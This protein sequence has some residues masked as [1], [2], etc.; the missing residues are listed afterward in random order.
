M[1]RAR[2]SRA[3][4]RAR[5]RTSPQYSR[6]GLSTNR[7][8]S[9]CSASAESTLRYS[10]GNVEIPNRHSRSGRAERAIVPARKRRDEALG[11]RGLMPAAEAC[12]ERAPEQRVPAGFFAALEAQAAAPAGRPRSRRT[13]ARCAQRAACAARRRGRARDSARS[14]RTPDRRRARASSAATVHISTR[15]S[16]AAPRAGVALSPSAVSNTRSSRWRGNGNCALPHTRSRRLSCIASQR[17]MPLLWTTISSGASGSDSGRCTTSRQHVDEPL[18]AIAAVEE[19]RAARGHT[20]SRAAAAG[21]G[22]G[23]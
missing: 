22:T 13:R 3:R 23:R 8:V 14:A 10:G 16:N 2:R 19:H 15:S 18:A 7:C 6:D 17:S 20:R 21:A 12:D 11:A 9:T 5:L 1:A 4:A